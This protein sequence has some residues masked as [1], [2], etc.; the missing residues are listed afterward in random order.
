MEKEREDKVISQG[1]YASFG[2][3]A[4]FPEY[5]APPVVSPT[6][7]LMTTMPYSPACLICANVT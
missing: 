1:G 6:K 2:I 7:R 4:L 3:D 5:V